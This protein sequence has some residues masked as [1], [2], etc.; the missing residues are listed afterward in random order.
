MKLYKNILSNEFCDFLIETIKTECTLSELYKK[1]GWYI[2]LIW[3]ETSGSKLPKEKWNYNILNLINE[4]LNKVDSEFKNHKLIWLQM[5]EYENNRSL[6]RH[7][8][9][10]E[11]KT[12]SIILSDGFIGGNTFINDKDVDLKKGDGVL[13]DG[14]FQFHEVK[15]VTQGVRYALN[16]WF[17]KNIF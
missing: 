10:A 3:G 2:W 5:T 9:G 4:E 11:N 17:H 14:A 7:V 13:F 1:Y 8:D 16:F 6:R 15:P 12:F